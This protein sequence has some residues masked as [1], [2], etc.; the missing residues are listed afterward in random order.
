MRLIKGRLH[1]L[2]WNVSDQVSF[3]L[4]TSYFFCSSFEKNFR[5]PI[6]FAAQIVIAVDLIQNIAAFRRPI[7]SLTPRFLKLDVVNFP[8]SVTL[9]ASQN[10]KRL[11]KCARNEAYASVVRKVFELKPLKFILLFYYL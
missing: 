4:K 1:F 10:V 3:L 9:Q 6:I 11:P 8:S 7:E 5:V 2:D